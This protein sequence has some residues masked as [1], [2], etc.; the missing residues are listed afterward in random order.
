MAPKEHIRS[1]AHK[2]AE[3]KSEGERLRAVEEESRRL[4]LEFKREAI[5]RALSLVVG[6]VLDPRWRRRESREASPWM[7]MQ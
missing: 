5:E 6:R 3:A 2:L 1:L 7:C 4:L